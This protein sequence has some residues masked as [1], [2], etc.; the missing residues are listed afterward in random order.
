MDV[1]KLGEMSIKCQKKKKKKKF[2]KTKQTHA[3]SK[4][5]LINSNE[6]NFKVQMAYITVGV[7]KRAGTGEGD[8]CREKEG[9]VY[10]SVMR[11]CTHQMYS[12]LVPGDVLCCA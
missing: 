10:T 2:N 11:F 4:K 8:G 9:E 5:S 7:K 1:T 3:Q 12:Q 6:I